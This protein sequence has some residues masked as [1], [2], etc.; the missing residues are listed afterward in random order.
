MSTNHILGIVKK[1]FINKSLPTEHSIRPEGSAINNGQKFFGF[2]QLY[3]T[4]GQQNLST[5]PVGSG[6]GVGTTTAPLCGGT[7]AILPPKAQ[8]PINPKIVMNFIML[9]PQLANTRIFYKICLFVK[10]ILQMFK[11]SS[12]TYTLDSTCFRVEIQ[13]YGC[14]F[15]FP[16]KMLIKWNLLMAL[17]AAAPGLLPPLV[18]CLD[19]RPIIV[20][21]LK[22]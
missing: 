10:N 8:M 13:T 9:T 16:E 5:H 7:M 11:K 14:V 15:C 20:I 4:T 2:F 19:L 18:F 12:F 3:L 6:G 1:E 22:L 21:P 17:V